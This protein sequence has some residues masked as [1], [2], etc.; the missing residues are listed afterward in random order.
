[1]TLQLPTKHDQRVAENAIDNRDVDLSQ[2]VLAVEGED[3]SDEV[4]EGEWG[5]DSSGATSMDFTLGAVLPRRLE[6]APVEFYISIKGIEIPL[7]FGPISAFEVGEDRVTT[8][9]FWAATPGALWARTTLDE[10][11]EFSG[12][13]PENIVREAL[14]RV[15]YKRGAVRVSKLQE[16]TL[17]FTRA[18]GNAFKSDQFV[19]DIL[20]AVDEQ[21]TYVFRDTARGGHVADPAVSLGKT[22]VP[23]VSFDASEVSGWKP[24][25]RADHRYSQVTVQRENPDG[26]YSYRQTAPI[27]YRGSNRQPYG[28]QTFYVNLDEAGSEGPARAQQLAYDMA[29]NFAR[30]VYAGE[31]PWPYFNPFLERQDMFGVYEDHRDMDGTWSR[32]WI[33]WIDTFKHVR[34]RVSDSLAA[35]DA[36]QTTVAYRATLMEEELIRVPTMILPGVSSGVIETVVGPA[37]AGSFTHWGQTDYRFEELQQPYEELS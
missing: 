22:R 35:N 2:F 21:T 12:W 4:L 11:V 28:H 8:D 33:C 30:G 6:E 36:I 29:S 7:L 34:S 13:T 19:S 23:R 24:P 9:P 26:T 15:P 27:T 20:D 17:F 25:K 10:T 18:L 3:I 32:F 31:T 5:Q 37:P 1:M 14:G 16:P